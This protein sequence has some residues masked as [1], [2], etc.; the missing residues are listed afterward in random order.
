M[1]T[2]STTAGA[3]TILITIGLTTIR[4]IITMAVIPSTTTTTTMTRTTA[5]TMD[6]VIT[7]GRQW[8]TATAVENSLKTAITAEW[9]AEVMATVK[10]TTTTR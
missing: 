8:V 6:I 9:L 4:G 10:P 7:S 1:T 2:V 3:G 5:T